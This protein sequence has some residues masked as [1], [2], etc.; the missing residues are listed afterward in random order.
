MSSETIDASSP[1][2]SVP[3]SNNESSRSAVYPLAASG[4]WLIA[5]LLAAS[6]TNTKS[7]VTP[8]FSRDVAPILATH[9]VGCHRQGHAAPFPLTTFAEV[10]A[11]ADAIAGAVET[12]RM[13]P[14]LPEHDNP[15]FVGERRL[16]DQQIATIR[17]WVAAGAPEGAAPSAA[18]PLPSSDWELSS[19]DLVAT[20]P[21]AYNLPAAGHDIYRNVILPV[22]LTTPRRVRAVELRTNGAPIHHAVIRIDRTRASRARDG[23]DGQPGFEGMAAY[24]VQDPDGHFLGWAPGRGPIVAPED[25]PWTIE[26]GSDLVVELHLMPGESVARVRPSIGLYFTDRAPTRTPVLIVMGSKAIDIPAEAANYVI[27]DRY[28]LPVEVEVLSV[29]PHAHYLGRSM[30]VRATTPDGTSRQLLRIPRWSFNWQQ[31]YR[32]VNPIALPKGTIIAMRYT[33]DNSIGNRSNPHR[34]PRRVTWGPQSHDEMGNLGLQLLTRSPEDAKILKHSFEQHAAAIDVAGAETLV[35]ADPDNASHA[36]FLGTSY[37]RVGRLAD[38]VAPLERSLRLAPESATNHN[39]LAGVLLALGHR[40]RA[41]EH[42]QKAVALAPGDAHLRYNLARVLADSG[43]GSQAVQELTRTIV[44]DPELAEAHQLLGALFFAA[45]QTSKA[46]D[47]LT[48]ASGLAPASASIHADLGGALAQAGRL[49]EARTHLA[50][51]IELDP[52]DATARENLT[53]LERLLR[54]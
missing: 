12:H 39:H 40:A 24:E 44:L 34:P 11:R 27:E 8:T 16:S 43:R 1:W 18:V 42:F 19:P 38:A 31:D 10:Q 13:P 52:S 9:C 32:L 7:D 36:A 33:Y 48:R 46:I 53:R 54:R 50:R 25:M 17:T 5:S 15:P 35:R 2:R 29:Y 30:E 6:C 28:Q 49:D 14:W 4:L 47:H 41:F 20:M 23:E 22:P 45:G 37:V 51:A 21:T 3:G 26:P